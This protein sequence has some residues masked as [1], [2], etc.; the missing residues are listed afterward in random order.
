MHLKSSSSSGP[1]HADAV[2][3]PIFKSDNVMSELLESD[4]VS[5]AFMFKTETAIMATMAKE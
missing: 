3:V 5:L 4:V 1:V 2:C